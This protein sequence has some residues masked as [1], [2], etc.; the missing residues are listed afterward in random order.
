M[1]PPPHVVLVNPRR[2]LEVCPTLLSI[3]DS[4][5][6]LLMSLRTKTSSLITLGRLV[7]LSWFHITVTTNGQENGRELKKR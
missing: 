7:W 2:Y 5:E 4:R 1:W 6:V 3:L